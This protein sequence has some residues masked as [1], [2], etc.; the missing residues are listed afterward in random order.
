M[1]KFHILVLLLLLLLVVVVVVLKGGFKFWGIRMNGKDMILGS[2]NHLVL[3]INIESLAA[4]LFN[5]F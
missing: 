3:T 2:K 1:Y 4:Y 5:L